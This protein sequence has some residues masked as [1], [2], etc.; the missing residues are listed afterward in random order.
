[1]AGQVQKIE[2]PETLPNE[3]FQGVTF[4]NI[5]PIFLEFKVFEKFAKNENTAFSVIKYAKI[6]GKQTKFSVIVLKQLQNQNT[7]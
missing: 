5:I 1:M 2:N 6:S 4:G 7:G 3:L